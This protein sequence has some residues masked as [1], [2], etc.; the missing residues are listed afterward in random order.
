MDLKKLGKLILKII[1]WILAG[2]LA[3]VLLLIIVKNVGKLFVYHEFYSIDKKEAKI[4]GLNAGFVPQ[5]ITLN[6]ETDTFIMAG[7]TTKN[8]PSRLYTKSHKGHKSSYFEMYSEGKPFY[9]HTGGIQ[10]YKGK[11]YLANESDGVYIFD[12][13][14]TDKNKNSSGKV[15][16]GSKV[17]VNNHSSFAF[18]DS[19]SVYIGEFG[20]GKEYPCTNTITYN[21]ITNDSII[22]KYADGDL[23]KPVAV[24]SIPDL[25]QGFCITENGT[26]VLSTSWGVNPSEFLIYEADEVIETGS[27]Y[28]GLPLYFLG[29]PGRKLK[30]PQMSED[31]DLVEGRPFTYS[32][33]ASNKY[34]FG[35]I[36]FYNSIYSMNIK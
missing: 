32:E 29:E 7:Y 2:I 8:R 35:K 16:I 34:F 4:P 26:I 9:G 28:Q 30:A 25:V 1:G 11:L 5:G 20:N 13:S 27:A 3:L 21:G 23:S 36:L 33:S 6:T 14:L 24:Y 10:Y 12:A 18:S 17:N 31:L 22:T 19:N 15:E